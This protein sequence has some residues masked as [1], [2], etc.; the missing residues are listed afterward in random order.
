[1]SKKKCPKEGCH[2]PTSM[3]MELYSRE[4]Q[5]CPHF[6][7]DNTA[8]Q[9]MSNKKKGFKTIPWDGQAFQPEQI[10]VLSHRSSPKI[11]GLIGSSG[12]GKTTYLAM[13]YSLLFNGKKIENWDFAGSYTLAEWELLAKTL[14]IQENGTVP[15]PE[16]TPSGSDYYALFHLALRNN[17]FLNDVLFA[18]SSGEVFS[19]WAD[20]VDAPEASNARW[21]YSNSNAFL[22]FVDCV[23]VIDNRGK[24]R[25]NIV[26]LAEQLA[27]ELNDRPVIILW[28]K[29]D[30]EEEAR[31]NI[32][33]AIDRKLKDLFPNSPHL[34]ISNYSK[35]DSDEL[36][37][38]NNL[39]SV[40]L[41]LEKLSSTQVPSIEP[42]VESGMDFFIKYR[43]SNECE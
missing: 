25:K 10:H 27:S 30:R 36:C 42:K 9:E 1:M 24:A 5:L 18:D 40:E 4:Y 11:L 34:K 32:I 21:I 19:K 3:C 15:Y 7:S 26:Q 28:S 20:N 16:A 8:N 41:V 35:S 12:A 38:V 33:E 14:Q 39:R 2:A 13:I 17:G 37:H 43:G 31:A 23:S 29:A 6:N 22:L